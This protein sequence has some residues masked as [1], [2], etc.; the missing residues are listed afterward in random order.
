[1]WALSWPDVLLD[2]LADYYVAAAPDLRQRMAAGV[3]GLN[4]R[5]RSDPLDVGESRERGFRIAFA[6]GLVVL[7]R[8]D[9]A[10]RKVVISDVRPYGR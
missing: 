1:M 5:L 6:P 4:T 10:A 7:F 8:V 3:E 9:V 2:L